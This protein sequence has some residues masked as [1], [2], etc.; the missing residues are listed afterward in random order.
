MLTQHS[1]SVTRGGGGGNVIMWNSWIEVL[2]K[3]TSSTSSG[4]CV[5]IRF[6]TYSLFSVFS[7][8]KKIPS[9]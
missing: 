1:W 5:D 7:T 6:V 8:Q 9:M 4:S 3:G 2:T